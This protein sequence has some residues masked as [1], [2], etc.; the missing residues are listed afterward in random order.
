MKAIRREKGFTFIELMVSMVIASLVF[1]GIYG[2]YRI[3]QKSYTVQEQVTELQQ[4]LRS[5][6]DR[7]AIEIRMAGSNPASESLCGTKI[8]KAETE[9]MIFNSCNPDYKSNNDYQITISFNKATGELSLTRDLGMNGALS[10]PIAD[11]VDGVELKYFDKDNKELT[12]ISKPDDEIRSVQITLRF[13]SIYPDPKY[14]DPK[15]NDNYHRRTLQSRVYMRN[16][17]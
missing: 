13:R 7:L 17:L 6:M 3:Q 11:A 8:V 4:R 16:M 14:F 5:A 10:K 15:Y 2:V 9:E 1:A 12:V